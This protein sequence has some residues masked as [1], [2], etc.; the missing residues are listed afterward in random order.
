M[1]LNDVLVEDVPGV[2]DG[3]DVVFYFDFEV[4]GFVGVL[5][6]LLKNFR[7]EVGKVGVSF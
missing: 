3:L 4:G 6:K 5:P 7:V 1:T 2:D